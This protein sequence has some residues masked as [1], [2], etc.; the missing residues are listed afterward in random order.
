MG[1]RIRDV[2][3]GA[4]LGPTQELKMN[5]KMAT[6]LTANVGILEQTAAKLLLQRV[7]LFE[8]CAFY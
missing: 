4:S 8:S 2:S 3:L 6:T 7:V 5:L 1:W